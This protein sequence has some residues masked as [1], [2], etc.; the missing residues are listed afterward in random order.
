MCA[1]RAVLGFYLVYNMSYIYIYI[2]GIPADVRYL[3]D[4]CFAKSYQG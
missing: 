4:S 2:L 3:K 1:P